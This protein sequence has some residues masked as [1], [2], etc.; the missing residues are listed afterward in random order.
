M[1]IIIIIWR[2]V[3]ES[4]ISERRLTD[5]ARAIKLNGWLSDDEMEELTREVNNEGGSCQD[6]SSST[7]LISEMTTDNESQ[8]VYESATQ[9]EEE[10]GH[11]EHRNGPSHPTSEPQGT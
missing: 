4:D 9:S 1:L 2:D 5:Q 10:R 8:F 7:Y 3:G 11:S 6:R